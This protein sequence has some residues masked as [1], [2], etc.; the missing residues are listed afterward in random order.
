MLPEELALLK[1]NRTS[2]FD[3]QEYVSFENEYFKSTLDY[4]LLPKG[5]WQFEKIEIL[6][7]VSDHH[8]VFVEI[9]M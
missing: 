4:S 9:K 8:G 6:K 5:N 7:G 1:G 2:S 3:F